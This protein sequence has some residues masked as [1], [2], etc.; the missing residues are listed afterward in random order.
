MDPDKPG[1][2]EVTGKVGEASTTVKVTVRSNKE[3]AA[4]TKQQYDPEDYTA[5]SYKA[6]ET[7]LAKAKTVLQN[8][9]ATQKEIDAASDALKD[10][11]SGLKRKHLLSQSVHRLLSMKEKR[12]S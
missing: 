9:D 11:I 5:D 10:A 4:L 12:F 6:Y 2:Y 8:A 7:A 1:V 3:L